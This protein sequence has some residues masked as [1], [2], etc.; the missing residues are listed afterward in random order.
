MKTYVAKMKCVLI[1]VSIFLLNT[2]TVNAGPVK[3]AYV[4]ESGEVILLKE[5]LNTKFPDGGEIKKMKVEVFSDGY[6]LVRIGKSGTTCRTEVM[7]LRRIANDLFFEELKWFTVCSMAE[8]GF[9][10]PN[11]DK[12]SCNCNGGERNGQECNF[13]IDVTYDTVLIDNFEYP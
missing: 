1:T 11:S 4:K 8:C 13:G 2:M 6:N 9:C 7:P 12:T 5:R 10:M 3:I